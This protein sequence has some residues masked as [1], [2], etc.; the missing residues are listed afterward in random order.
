MSI[1]AG[2]TTG[3]RRASRSR[4]AIMRTRPTPRPSTRGTRSW[5]ASPRC[6]TS[7]TI[8]S[9]IFSL[10]DAI[11][12]RS[13]STARRIVAAGPRHLGHRAAMAT[14][15]ASTAT[16]TAIASPHA[17]QRLQRRRRLPPRGPRADLARRR[18]DQVRGD[19]RSPLATSPAASNQQM[20]R[21]R[22]A[23]DRRDRA[24]RSAAASPPMPM[25]CDGINAALEAGVDSIEH[26][27][28]TNDAHLPALPPDRRLLR[29]DPARAGRGRSP[30]AARGAL[31]PGPI[32][33]GAGGRRQRRAQLRPGR[34]RRDQHRLRNRQRRQPARP[35]RRGVRVDG[36]QRHDPDGGDPLGHGRAP[37]PCSAARTASGR[38]RS[39]RMRTSSPSPATRCRTS[40]CSKTSAS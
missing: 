35:Q 18:S 17:D 23:R 9:L 19:R 33:E 32:S 22:D 30:T 38:S 1:C 21:G 40:A 29:A 16:S 14:S 10:R 11:A 36:S 2:S 8:P 26:G 7:A 3:F 5:P 28:F 31:T 15:T 27:T 13:S 12:C 24:H 25:A 39:A 6:A 20:M 34:A 37:P 4:P